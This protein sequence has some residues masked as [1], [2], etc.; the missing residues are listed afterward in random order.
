[1]NSAPKNVLMDSSQKIDSLAV[2]VQV[3]LPGMA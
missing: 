3:Q 1:M 2:F